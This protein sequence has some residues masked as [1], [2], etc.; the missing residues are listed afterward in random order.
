MSLQLFLFNS[1]G[2]EVE[3]LP[4]SCRGGISQSVGKQASRIIRQRQ[5]KAQYTTITHDLCRQLQPPPVPSWRFKRLTVLKCIIYNNEG[6]KRD[7][8]RLPATTKYVNG[9]KERLWDRAGEPAHSA[10]TSVLWQ[11]YVNI[12]FYTRPKEPDHL[13]AWIYIQR[14][15]P[16]VTSQHLQGPS[17]CRA[18]L[19]L[20]NR[21][22]FAQS[23]I[24]LLFEYV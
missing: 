15:P 23:L 17:Q 7:V 14:K 5:I 20:F 12:I 1:S 18:V 6:G 19:L 11:H 2:A 10:Q 13:P 8:W 4:N 16:G 3:K 22:H 21:R 9:N 24:F